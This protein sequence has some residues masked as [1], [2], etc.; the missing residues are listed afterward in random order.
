MYLLTGRGEGG[1]ETASQLVDARSLRNFQFTLSFVVAGEGT[2][3]I[4]S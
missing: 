3:G 4:V 2:A 1:M